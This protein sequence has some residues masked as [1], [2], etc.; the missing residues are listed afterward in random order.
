MKDDCLYVLH[1]ASQLQ[2]YRINTEDGTIINSAIW[3]SGGI[4]SAGNGTIKVVGNLMFVG[5]E[6][7]GNPSMRVYDISD[8]DN[9]VLLSTT[10]PI[11]P[12]MNTT[13]DF[14]TSN[15]V[16]QIGIYSFDVEDRG[17]GIYRVYANNRA[18][19]GENETQRYFL[20]IRDITRHLR[21]ATTRIN[22]GNFF[23]KKTTTP[24]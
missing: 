18:K 16:S 20:S 19:F 13:G 23:C 1:G 11:Y 2:I 12:C 21:N 9:P 3:S 17:N 10:T 24:H 5:T 14:N 8:S 6:Y 7:T 22:T 15:C 4:S